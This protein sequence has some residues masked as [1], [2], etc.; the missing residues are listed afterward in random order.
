MKQPQTALPEAIPQQPSPLHRPACNW[1]F[2]LLPER[3]EGGLQVGDCPFSAAKRWK[4]RSGAA[5]LHPPCLIALP[6]SPPKWKDPGEG[7][8]HSTA[9]PR[10]LGAT[11]SCWELLGA[12]VRLRRLRFPAPREGKARAGACGLPRPEAGGTVRARG[13]GHGGG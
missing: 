6:P 7:G 2:K 10:I 12:V 9:L 11:G 4:D 5:D 1:G 8:G 3:L 13:G